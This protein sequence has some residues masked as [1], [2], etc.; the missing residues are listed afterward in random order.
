M[1]RKKTG[2]GRREGRK[3][4]IPALLLAK[5][6]Q[7]FYTIITCVG[8]TIQANSR[9]TF[10]AYITIIWRFWQEKFHRNFRFFIFEAVT[11]PETAPLEKCRGG[12][13]LSLNIDVI[14]LILDT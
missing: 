1:R 4:D 14:P 8:F 10:I 12:I 11:K 6:K 9:L 13:P 3:R 5:I 7:I 2:L